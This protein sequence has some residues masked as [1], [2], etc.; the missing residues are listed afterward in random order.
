MLNKTEENQIVIGDNSHQIQAEIINIYQGISEQRAREICLEIA[1]KA[2]EENTAGALE[3]ANKRLDEFK[4]I[5]I[6]DI[7]KIEK[8]FNSFSD[9]AF[10]I[11]LKKAQLTAACTERSYDYKI[12]AELLAHRIENKSSIKKKASITKVVEILDQIDDDALCGLTT[13]Y[14]VKKFVPTGSS[15][16]DCLS[17]LNYLFGEIMYMDLPV[18]Y[19]WIDHLELLGMIRTFPYNEINKL[20][21][22]LRE[23]FGGYICTGIRKSSENYR[24]V[25][26]IIDFNNIPQDILV[27]NEF[28]NDYTRL[29]IVNKFSIDGR[30]DKN[31]RKALHD[32]WSMYEQNSRLQKNIEEKF[33]EQF[34]SYQK[35]SELK[36]WWNNISP[37]FILTSAGDVLAHANA[38]RCYDK[39]PI[40]DR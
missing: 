23:N 21:Y 17:K 11:L 19:N 27:D 40:F 39:L 28:C 36:H 24:K 5:L 14:S 20:P 22:C 37:Y 10:Q 33:N 31:Q 7:E 6:P 16:N 13:Y 32:I 38:K 2:I 26:E 35:L 29:N 12:L 34:S 3:I 25:L 30:Y 4:S 18:G 1:K 8:N 15:M 9:P